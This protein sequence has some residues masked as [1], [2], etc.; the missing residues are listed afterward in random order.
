MKHLK[1]IVSLLLT[2]VMVLA[3][4]I[5]VMAANGTGTITMSGSDASHVYSIYQILVGDY[6][7]GKLSNVKWGSATAKSGD[8]VTDAELAK[9]TA[10]SNNTQD[11]ADAVAKYITDDAVATDTI[12]GN[13]SAT[14]PTGYYV[15]KDSY[16]NNP[17]EAQSVST[18]LVKVVGKVDVTPK[19]GVPTSDKKVDDKNDSNST[20]DGVNWKDS[21]DYDIGDAVPFRLHGTLPENFDSYKTYK[22][23][24]HDQ[25]S[26][27]LLLK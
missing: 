7:D 10:L 17:D 9:F 18:Y 27:G 24:F 1:K 8:N 25:E 20:E 5:P 12:N 26:E 2:A 15:I 3:M 14:V 6:A 22:Y 11:T 13:G 23:I 21:A 4:C 16:I 19:V